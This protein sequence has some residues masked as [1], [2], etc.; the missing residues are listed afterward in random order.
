MLEYSDYYDFTNSYP[1]NKKSPDGDVIE[2]DN[3]SEWSDDY[4]SDA[5]SVASEDLGRVQITHDL[6]ELRLP[7]VGKRLG[8]RS[9]ARYYRQNLRPE[10]TLSQG[11]QTHRLM[12]EAP[13]VSPGAP[14]KPFGIRKFGE[15]SMMVEISK[16]RHAEREARRFRDQREKEDFR[17]G[18][19][20]RK[21]AE[22]KKYYRG[23]ISF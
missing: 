3:D 7:H 17:S 19:A 9:L 14:K 8:H 10:K 16:R 1:S 4:D 23:T 15:L 20:L 13:G 12:I 11:E 21:T 18:L 5:S 22:F 2:D 6:L